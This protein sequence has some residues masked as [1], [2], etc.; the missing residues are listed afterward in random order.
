MFQGLSRAKMSY[1]FNHQVQ[2]RR[3]TSGFYI[4]QGQVIF[5][6]QNFHPG[7]SPPPFHDSYSIGVGSSAPGVKRLGRKADR[8]PLSGAEVTSEDT[9]LLP[10]K[11]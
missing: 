2:V 10:Y 4:R 1:V 3:F 8:S 6:P 7:S 11:H 5:T 9:R